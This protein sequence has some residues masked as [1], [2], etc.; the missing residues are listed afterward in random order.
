MNTDA[1][2]V[3][4]T[5]DKVTA[6]LDRYI[7]VFRKGGA[8]ETA[9]DSIGGDISWFDDIR[10][11]FDELYD[12]IQDAHMYSMVNQDD[13]DMG[14]SESVDAVESDNSELEYIKTLAGL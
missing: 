12:A 7:K 4:N 11:K 14:E 10:N 8:L 13:E 1:Q 2:K 5:F 9:V 3:S 6:E